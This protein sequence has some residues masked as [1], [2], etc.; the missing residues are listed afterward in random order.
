MQIRPILAD[1]S[2]SITELKK[3]PAAIVESADGF[4]IAVLSHNQP[5]FYCVPADAYERIIDKLED[6][7]L[8]QLVMD[9]RASPEKEVSLDDL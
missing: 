2:T 3:N 5:I 7:E 9:R 8:A 1:C 4:P 6:I